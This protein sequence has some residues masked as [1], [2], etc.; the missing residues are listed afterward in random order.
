MHSDSSCIPVFP[1]L[2]SAHYAVFAAFAGR[3]VLCQFFLHLLA[4]FVVFVVFLALF[5]KYGDVASK[6][7]T[8]LPQSC[9]IYTCTFQYVLH[10]V[11]CLNFKMR[12]LSCC[13]VAQTS[14]I[15][16]V[17]CFHNRSFEK[18]VKTLC[19]CACIFYQWAAHLSGPLVHTEV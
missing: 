8:E 15:T 14:S 3:T 16:E 9:K 2:V 11:W 17:Q 13:H 4:C 6:P 7:H 19:Q 12:C 18:T 10:F 1:S 5:L